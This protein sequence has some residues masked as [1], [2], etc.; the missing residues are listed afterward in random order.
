MPTVRDGKK[1]GQAGPGDRT[2]ASHRESSP[3][4]TSLLRLQQQQWCVALLVCEAA[5]MQMRRRLSV[6]VAG[7]VARVTRWGSALLVAALLVVVSLPALARA[8]ATSHGPTTPA[9]AGFHERVVYVDHRAVTYYEGGHGPPL[10]L[11]HG[12]PQT[13]YEWHRVMP[14]LAQQ[15]RV[16]VPDL[17]GAGGSAAASSYRKVV[18][19]DH[20]VH[21]LQRIKAQPAAVVG[22]DIGGMVAYAMAARAPTVVRRVAILDVPL[23]GVGPW[24]QVLLNKGAWHFGFHQQRGLA[25][26]LTQ[27]RESY[28]LTRFFREKTGNDGAFERAFS[29]AEVQTFVHQYQRPGRMSAGFEWYRAFNA[30]ERDFRRLAKSPLLMPVLGIGGDRS[31]GALMGPVLQAV[32]RAPLVA[33]LAHTGHWLPEERPTALTA[34]L[35]AFLD[36]SSRPSR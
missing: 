33:T 28:Y 2:S 6:R 12:W 35:L 14:L 18:V 17:P 21:F 1:T 8:Q 30:D 20:L 4:S 15:Y 25:E 9:V 7:S 23:P 27:G 13:A 10:L 22:H 16:I 31:S 5:A 32:A 24:Q 11:L 36:A 34:R 26:H 19:A 3:T 29:G